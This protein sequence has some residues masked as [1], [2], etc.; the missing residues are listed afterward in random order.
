MSPTTKQSLGD[1]GERLVV[2]HVQCPGCKRGERTLR[3]LP[4]NFKCAD[5]ICDFCGYLAQ[6]KTKSWTGPLPERCPSP[7][8]GAAWGPQKARMGAGL[9]FSLFV[10]VENE[11]G[12]MGIY[13]LPRDLQSEEMF[14]PRKP[15]SETAKRAGWQG[16][17]IDLARARAWPTRYTDGESDEFRLKKAKRPPARKVLT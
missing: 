15:L 9:Y 7:I 17:M 4:P 8:I 11:E 16:F 10:V 6:V 1:R 5:V 3:Q 14:V 2:Q 13:F 12:A